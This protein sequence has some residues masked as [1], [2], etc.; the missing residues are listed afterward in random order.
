MGTIF[1]QFYET[2]ELSC[3]LDYQTYLHQDSGEFDFGSERVSREI[4]LGRVTTLSFDIALQSE[5]D[6]LK[7]RCHFVSNRN[8]TE[9]ARP[10]I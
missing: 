3:L 4:V 1:V 6:H 5:S 9:A 7:A 8:R 2:R 10:E